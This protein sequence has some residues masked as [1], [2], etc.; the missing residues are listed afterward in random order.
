MPLYGVDVSHHQGAVNWRAV[1]GDGIGFAI[2]KATEG[3]GFVDSRFSQNWHGIRENEMSRGA[4]HF[5]HPGDGAA[6]ARHYLDVVRPQSG[7]LLVVDVERTAS[8]GRPTRD[9]AAE[10]V[11]E[12]RRHLPGR[13]VG[14]Y[15]GMWYWKDLLGN[16]PLAPLGVW[17]WESRYVGGTVPARW[18]DLAARVNDGWFDQVRSGG[19]RPRVIQFQSQGLVNGVAGNCDVNVTPMSIDALAALGGGEDDMVTREDVADVVNEQLRYHLPRALAVCLGERSN[20]AYTTD[21]D[22]AVPDRVT[23]VGTEGWSVRD[24]LAAAVATI[25]GTVPG[26]D[27]DALA[28]K[29]AERLDG[30]TGDQ[31]KAALREVFADAG[32]EG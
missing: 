11:T 28:E 4:Y 2:V 17:L 18:R 29:I 20:A 16:P 14:L 7:D 32:T 30:A 15:T 31:V 13:P 22:N 8:G 24:L 19:L 3:T 27:L 12:V 6:Q 21:P 9:D 26:V 25:G 23:Y 1:K 10:F 5:L